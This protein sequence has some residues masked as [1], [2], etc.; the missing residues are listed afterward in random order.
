[1][2]PPAERRFGSIHVDL[3]GPLPEAE[4]GYKYLLMIVD[5]FSRWPEAYPLKDMTS[6]SCCRAFILNWLPCFGIPDTI[7]TDRGSQF[8]GGAWKELMLSLGVTSLST[9][10]YHPQCNGLV[11]RMHCQLKGAIRARLTSANWCDCL[12]LVLLG[13]RSAWRSGPD[14]APSQ[15]LY[16]TMLQLPGQFIPA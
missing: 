10:A 8:I 5:R 3:V 7:V 13:L 15:L 12:P 6:Q 4:G 11:E 9:T 16:G 14:A 2:L 1:M